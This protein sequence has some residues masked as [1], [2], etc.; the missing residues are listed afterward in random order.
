MSWPKELIEIILA[1]LPFTLCRWLKIEDLDLDILSMNPKAADYLLE[2]PFLIRPVWAWINPGLVKHMASE[3]Y[4]KGG[5]ITIPLLVFNTNIVEVKEILPKERLKVSEIADIKYISS[6]IDDLKKFWRSTYINMM[7]KKLFS[8]PNFL[9]DS[10]P[11]DINTIRNS[12][13][14]K[15]AL[16]YNPAIFSQD[17]L[18]Q[19]LTKCLNH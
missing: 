3:S 8:K 9:F 11:S 5:F 13:R 6:D 18:R 4:K 17:E 10:N 15:A 2:R 12:N 7:N 19:Y 1:F 14:R 16:A